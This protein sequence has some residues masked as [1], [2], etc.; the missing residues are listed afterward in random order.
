MNSLK[1]IRCDS[2]KIDAFDCPICQDTLRVSDD[3]PGKLPSKRY[4]SCPTCHNHFFLTIDARLGY[5]GNNK[6]LSL[7]QFEGRE[8]KLLNQHVMHIIGNSYDTKR[9]RSI[10]RITKVLKTGFRISEQESALFAFNGRQKIPS[11]KFNMGIVS[12]CELYTVEEINCIVAQWKIYKAKK[13]MKKE[14]KALAETVLDNFM[15]EDQG[16]QELEFIH[17]LFQGMVDKKFMK[18]DLLKLFNNIAPI[19]PEIPYP[20][21]KD[22]LKT[23]EITY[24]NPKTLRQYI[25]FTEIGWYSLND[26]GVYHK[27]IRPTFSKILINNK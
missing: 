2:T 20:Q 14:I 3:Q 6:E 26:V 8:E 24:N 12:Y 15:K 1:I 5:T 22:L 16:E 13:T 9:S 10:R 7:M 21:I 27:G 19:A 23:Y 4:V 17:E 11:L 18:E 25:N